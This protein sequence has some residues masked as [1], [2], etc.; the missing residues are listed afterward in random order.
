MLVGMYVKVPR[1]PIFL[2]SHTNLPG[3]QVLEFL[4]LPMG[5]RMLLQVS[6]REES[7]WR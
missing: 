5:L 3:Y 1:S 7:L 6:V 2:P 4:D